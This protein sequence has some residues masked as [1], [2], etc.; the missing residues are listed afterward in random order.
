MASN[1]SVLDRMLE[2]ALR[3]GWPA[4]GRSDG[5]PQPAGARRL[6]NLGDILR[7]M[8]VTMPPPISFRADR[9]RQEQA[10]ASGRESRSKDR[11][12]WGA[13]ASEAIDHGTPGSARPDALIQCPQNRRE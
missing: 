5:N 12:A 1:Q 8:P 13:S 11:Y 2:A 10:L 3:G 4:R 6:R 9:C 7:G